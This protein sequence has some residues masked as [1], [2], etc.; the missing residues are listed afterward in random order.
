MMSA[1]M[2]REVQGDSILPY[3]STTPPLTWQ[4][5]P[6]R[7]LTLLQGQD[8]TAPAQGHLNSLTL[9]PALL[10]IMGHNNSPITM[11]IMEPVNNRFM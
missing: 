10:S 7:C 3:S 9:H 4:V 11:G 2:L 8:I 5:L 1:C 6:L